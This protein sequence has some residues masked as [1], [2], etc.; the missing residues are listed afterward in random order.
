MRF[1][2]I[3]KWGKSGWGNDNASPALLQF[4]TVA[5]E[6]HVPV[7][8]EL[9][10][11]SFLW[12]GVRVDFLWPESDADESAPA[13]KNNDSLVVRL[14]YGNRTILL[15]GDAEKQ[16]EYS[17][18]SENATAELHADVL[19]IGHHGSKNSSMPDFLA[20][21]SP[22]IAIISA[23]EQNPYGHPS[24]ELIRRLQ[25]KGIHIL[26][27]DHG[28]CGASTN[29]WPQL[30]RELLCALPFAVKGDQ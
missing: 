25:D 27:T 11:Q 14:R 7:K 4:K 6:Q 1:C 17:I 8:H 23:G 2:K 29:R 26:R 24:P 30:K 20:A 19:K 28:W 3:S 10:G 18:L 16:V 12:D 9:R 5:R 21:V 22:Q 13:A 15:P